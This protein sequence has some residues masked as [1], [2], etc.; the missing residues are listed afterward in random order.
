MKGASFCIHR[1]CLCYWVFELP[2]SHLSPCSAIHFI[3][4]TLRMDAL[5]PPQVRLCRLWVLS[6]HFVMCALTSMSEVV[7]FKFNNPPSPVL[8]TYS[9]ILSLSWWQHRC[10]FWLISAK[11]TY[12]F[13]FYSCSIYPWDEKPRSWS[14]THSS[15]KV[16]SSCRAF[17]NIRVVQGREKVSPI[18]LYE[19]S[20]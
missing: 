19:L 4:L 14:G 11:V 8:P 9:F 7:I 12:L 17:S 18:W 6:L 20:W 1:T 3:F 10:F 15:A 5:S 16:R 2:L 13:V